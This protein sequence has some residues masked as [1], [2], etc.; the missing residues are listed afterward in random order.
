MT[1][2]RNNNRPIDIQDED[3]RIMRDPNLHN[4]PLKEVGKLKYSQQQL[5][6]AKKR[7]LHEIIRL[8]E[9]ELWES[10]HRMIS[11]ALLV[12]K[13]RDRAINLAILLVIILALIIGFY[14]YFSDYI[15]IRPP[16]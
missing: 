11:E 15:L 10:D 4:V 6:Q 8:L 1:G 9:N 12:D 5:D 2:Q 3:T 13:W 7:E 14:F 16:N